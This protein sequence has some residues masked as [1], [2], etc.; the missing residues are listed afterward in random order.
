MDVSSN[1]FITLK[2]ENMEALKNKDLMKRGILPVVINKCMQQSIE[3]KASNKEL[4]DQDVEQII[5]K[6]IKELD[7]EAIL[8]KKAGREEKYNELI[9][10]KNY[11]KSFLP[12]QLEKD[13]I[14]AIIN[15]LEDKSIGFVMK[16]FKQNYNGKCDMKLVNEVLKNIG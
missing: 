7:D 3:L 15:S 8:F 12:K 5:S 13:E 1:L 10:Q 9:A 16:Y 14:L 4:E 11:I 2:K 6:T